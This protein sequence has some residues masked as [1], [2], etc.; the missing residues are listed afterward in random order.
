MILRLLIAAAIVAVAVAVAYAMR[1]RRADAPTQATRTVP[2]QLDRTDF[3][4]PDAEW[5]VAVFTSGTC[6]TCAD[7][8]AAART[9]IDTAIDVAVVDVEFQALRPLHER[10]GIEA[11][12]L[13][14]IA[15]AEGVV[16]ASVFGPVGVADVG[17]ALAAARRAASGRGESQI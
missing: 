1:R 11:V 2:S 7:V 17:A 12:P 15:D 8:L 10:Y 16:R 6:D 14:V 9:L 4:R 5:L 3:E 13:L